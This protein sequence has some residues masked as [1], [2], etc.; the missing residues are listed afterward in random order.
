MQNRGP[1]NQAIRGLKVNTTTVFYT[2]DFQFRDLDS[3]LTNHL[4]TKLKY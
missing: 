4:I 2:R 3:G 1:D